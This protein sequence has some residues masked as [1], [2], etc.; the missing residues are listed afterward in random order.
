MYICTYIHINI[1]IYIYMY[2]L[3][4]THIYPQKKEGGGG[5]LSGGGRVAPISRCCNSERGGSFDFVFRRYQTAGED[6][7][8]EAIVTWLRE[9]ARPILFEVEVHGKE[10][11]VKCTLA[12]SGLTD[13]YLQSYK[14]SCSDPL[15]PHV[16]IFMYI[17][18]CLILSSSI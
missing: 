18:I 13:F 10:E 6:L 8:S 4:C 2:T 16:Y 7:T 9:G 12:C 15:P 14:S 5:S 1:Y 17:Y 11:K 3:T